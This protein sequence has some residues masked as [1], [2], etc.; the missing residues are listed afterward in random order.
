MGLWNTWRQ[1]LKVSKIPFEEWEYIRDKSI[2][3]NPNNIKNLESVSKVVWEFLSSIYNLHWDGLYVNNTNTIFRNKISSK[4]TSQ[5]PK[6]SN[7]NNKDKDMVKP[8][9]ISFIPLYSS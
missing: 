3:S 6:N 7:I 5:V 4:F 8:T 2:D 1:T 9:F